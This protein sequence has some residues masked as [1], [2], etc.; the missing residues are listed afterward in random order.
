[1][2]IS[3]LRIFIVLSFL[4]SSVCSFAQD[5]RTIEIIGTDT[6]YLKPLEFTYQVS[7][8]EQNNF[9]AFVMGQKGKDTMTVTTASEIRELLQKNRF[10]FE[11]GQES[12][13]TINKN[14][15]NDPVFSIKL[16]SISEL[17]RLF[18]SIKEL[19]GISGSIKEIKY[20][21][22]ALYKTEMYKHLY[23]TA[24]EDANLIAGIAGKSLG[25]II[26]IE[27]I[28]GPFDSLPFGNLINDM[29]SKGALAGLLYM[30][31]SFQKQV[32]KKLV[33]KFQLI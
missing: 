29:M 8:G 1:M 22:P 7:V 32:I 26:S 2:K 27:E 28:N 5:N 18:S 23:S 30:N 11:E 14:M 33:F 3:L 19:K 9:P 25:Q 13:Y 20:E 15:N 12:G 6:I 21:D 17:K 4:I 31:H 16:S 24:V 10:A